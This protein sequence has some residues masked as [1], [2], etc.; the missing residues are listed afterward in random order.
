MI[1]YVTEKYGSDNVAQV[2]TYGTMAAKAAIRDVGRALAIELPFVDQIAKLIPGKPGT[3]LKDAF[4]VEAFQTLYNTDERA[5]KIID[6]AK[7]LE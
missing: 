6:T 5:K 3:K 2:A 4:A 7:I 1:K